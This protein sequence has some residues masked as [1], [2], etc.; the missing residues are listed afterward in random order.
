MPEK[1][2]SLLG[3]P[4]QSLASLGAYQQQGGYTALRQALAGPGPL[5]VLGEMRAAGLRGR[6]GAGVLAAEKLALVARSAS[7]TRFLIC[8]A[9]DAD[10]RSRN[11]EALLERNPHVV[12]EG[13]IL[14]GFAA[15][16]HEGYLYLR[17]SRQ[18]AAQAAQTALREAQ[19][20]GLVG[21]NLAGSGFDFAI[22]LVGVE[23][24]F[25]GGE[26]SSVIEIIKGRPLK[27][28]QRPPYPTDMGL[29]GQ[30]TVMLNVETVA[31]LPA[32]VARGGQA[33]RATGTPATPGTKLL[34]VIG[35]SGASD[36]TQVI[37]VPFGTPIRLALRLARIEVN[38]STA[39][40][41]VVGGK[42][43]G[44]LP[45]GQLDT[46]LDYEP[47]EEAGVILGSALLEVLPRE[48]CMVRWAMGTM[49]EL[50]TESCGKCVP[51][52]VGVK[53]VAGTLESIASDLGTKDDLALLDDFIHYIADGS[54]C[55]FGVSAVNP[56][57]TAMRYFA[58]D[59]S[60]HLE[61]H[62]P[63]GTCLPVRA[64]RY[65]TKHVL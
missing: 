3:A 52:R 9:Y 34:T 44:A 36:E 21:R 11:A 31:N 45:L 42:E 55:G 1:Q 4:G 46:P 7:E 40:A 23:R 30:P 13:M 20:Q 29:Q 58:D 57:A 25:M 50:A 39:R 17:G 53:R 61:G 51:C 33:F 14:A 19:E 5:P 32:I 56:V 60:A 12:I 22:T 15:G 47:L 41:V 2:S 62:C 38:E 59:F 6:G 27:A 8:N 37:E 18:R 49:G 35:P 24:G 64:H 63:T 65:T 10:A 16:I 26:E 54:L 48:T 28:Q 43:G